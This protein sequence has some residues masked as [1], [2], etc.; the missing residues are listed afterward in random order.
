MRTLLIATALAIALPSAATAQVV[1]GAAQVADGDTLDFG[2]TQFDLAGIDAPELAQQCLRAGE[3][4]GCGA[5]ASSVLASFVEGKQLACQ[6]QSV[7][8]SGVALGYCTAQEMDLG[9]LMVEAGLA[10]ALDDAPLG[11]RQAQG[12][13]QEHAIG[14]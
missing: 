14:L 9:T 5:E 7:S 13:R 6:A 8:P 1:S 12:L 11:Y 2:G 10:V 3:T 4:W